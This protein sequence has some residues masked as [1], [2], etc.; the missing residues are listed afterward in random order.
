MYSI[1]LTTH[2]WV[3]WL[4]LLAGAFA[5]VSAG[6]SWRSRAPWPSSGKV[7]AHLVF[8][9]AVDIQLLLG[10]VLYATSPLVTNARAALKVAMRDPVM[11]FWA[12]EHA[13]AS[14]L[15]VVLVHVG[16]A[17]AKRGADAT[18]RFR[19]AAL[20]FGFALLC[21]LYANPWPWRIVGRALLP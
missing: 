17:L 14:I 20:F 18:A 2:S 1:A 15:G 7:P 5:V 16:Y 12:V 10:L 8:L 4:V 11:R 19:R 3:R 13:F 21:F 6:R 9:I